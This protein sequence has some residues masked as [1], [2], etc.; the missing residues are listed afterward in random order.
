VLGE[1]LRSLPKLETLSLYHTLVRG[2]AL[3]QLRGLRHLT[4]EVLPGSEISFE[5]IGTLG[6]LESLACSG[7]PVRFTHLEAVGRLPRL[8]CLSLP[9]HDLHDLAFVKSLQ[10]LE[11]LTLRDTKV[12]DIGPLQALTGLEELDL[13]CTALEK[14]AFQVLAR[15]EGLGFLALEDTCVDDEV[16]DG[17]ARLPAMRNLIIRK[18]SVSDRSLSTLLGYPKLWRVDLRET[19]V[20]PGVCAELRRA[21]PKLAL[22]CDHAECTQR[23]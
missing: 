15:L 3:S 19:R 5:A 22:L 12:L 7:K 6:T 20:S 1:K 9:L 4:I 16:L 17:L 23:Q 8:V 13:S 18:T 14:D 11:R 10:A 2:P 21:K